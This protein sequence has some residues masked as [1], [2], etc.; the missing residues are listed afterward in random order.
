MTDHVNGTSRRRWRALAAAIV[1]TALLALLATGCGDDD[2]SGATTASDTSGTTDGDGTSTTDGDDTSTTAG[3]STSTSTTAGG[4]TTT[5]GGGS[6]TTLP[7]EPWD[8]FADEGDVLAVVGVRY[9]DVL[10]IRSGP[11]TSYDIVATAGPTADD[12]VATGQ[13]RMAPGSIW[14]EVEVDGTTG[15]ANISFLAFL[16]DTDDATAEFVGG[17]T[18]PEAE[19]MVDLGELV[20][21]GFASEA[22]ASRVTQT[23]A[24]SVGDL[25][26]ITYDVVGLGDDALAGYRLHVFATPNEG[27]EGFGLRSIERTALCSRGTSGG[28]C[29]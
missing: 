19:T 1:A 20:A 5:A 6:A 2:D 14:Y 13:A 23:V 28:L 16:G 7:G 22:P 3:D 18:L 12:L 27:G 29:T 8:G 21:G 4:G 24:P 9:D 11:A 17:G 10:N 25:G 26:E 15:W